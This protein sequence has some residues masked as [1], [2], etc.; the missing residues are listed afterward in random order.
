MHDSVSQSRPYNLRRFSA[1]GY[2]L[3]KG[4]LA[5]VALL[6]V[7]Y[8]GLVFYGLTSLGTASRSMK[9]L[10][11]VDANMI[12]AP[13]GSVVTLKADTLAR[14]E[15]IAGIRRDSVPND[16]LILIFGRF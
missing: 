4:A 7:G 16:S 12:A 2:R 3:L 11:G 5:V 10:A 15:R 14:I 6:F 13:A 9:A 8:C 1:L